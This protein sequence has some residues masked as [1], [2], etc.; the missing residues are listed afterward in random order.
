M[1]RV[2]KFPLSG[3]EFDF[4]LNIPI[5]TMLTIKITLVPEV[6]NSPQWVD[7]LIARNLGL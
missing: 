7:N 1:G 3:S 6:A 2:I 5:D 4:F